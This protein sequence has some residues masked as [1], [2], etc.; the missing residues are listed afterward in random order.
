ME[1]DLT[2]IHRSSPPSKEST[3][4]PGMMRWQRPCASP[5]QD[6][7]AAKHARGA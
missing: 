2:G 5:P 1:L 4:N 3:R 6:P 7:H